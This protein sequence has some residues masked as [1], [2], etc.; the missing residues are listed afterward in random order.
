MLEPA[1][2]F[3]TVNIQPVARFSQTFSGLFG[4]FR[5][6]DFALVCVHAHAPLFMLSHPEFSM[7]SLWLLSN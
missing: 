3:V 5:F 2:R 4:V 6:Q 1:L 7:L